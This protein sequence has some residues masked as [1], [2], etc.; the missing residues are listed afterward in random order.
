MK[1]VQLCRGFASRQK[2][3]NAPKMPEDTKILIKSAPK[4]VNSAALV[5]EA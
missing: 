2:W 1:F 3:Q 5:I 4:Q